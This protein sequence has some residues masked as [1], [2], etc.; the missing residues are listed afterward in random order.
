MLCVRITQ[1]KQ[2]DCFYDRNVLLV[3]IATFFIWLAF[4]VF[5]FLCAG[6]FIDSTKEF[7]SNGNY[8]ANSCSKFIV[9]SYHITYLAD[10]NGVRESEWQDCLLVDKHVLY[11][12]KCCS[13]ISW[14]YFIQSADLSFGLKF[15]AVLT[16]YLYAL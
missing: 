11:L 8:E 3:L 5:C 15:T 7:F 6:Y 9:A 2:H 16:L 4:G 12:S 14:K 1:L 10:S 13:L